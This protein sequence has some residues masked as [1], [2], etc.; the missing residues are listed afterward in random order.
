MAGVMRGDGA[1]SLQL[2]DV[3]SHRFLL[4][5]EETPARQG[6]EL[7][8]T[9]AP[10]RVILRSGV[11]GREIYHLLSAG[12]ARSLLAKSGEATAGQAAAGLPAVPALDASV[13]ADEAPDRCIVL[14][15][16]QPS[17]F[18]DVD[19]DVHDVQRGRGPLDLDPEIVPRVLA[20]E[21]EREVEAGRTVSLLVALTHT[22]LAEDLG[23]PLALPIGSQVDVYVRPRRGF[24]LEGPR[25][26]S[27]VVTEDAE[28]L[29]VQFR[30]RAASSLGEGRVEVLAFHRGRCLGRLSLS[31]VIT[32]E[33]VAPSRPARY[34]KELHPDGAAEPDLALIIHE[35][36]DPARPELLIRLWSAEPAIQVKEFGPIRLLNDPREHFRSFFL[37][38]EALGGNDD[39]ARA[40]A[41]ER[42]ER[43]GAELFQTLLPEDLRVLLWSLRRRIGSLRVESEEP[44][45]PWEL[46]RLVGHEAGQIVESGFFCEE[47]VMG[48]WLLGVR[49][50]PALRLRRI[51]LIVPA[52]AGLRRAKEERDKV[53]GLEQE[54]LRVEP[55]SCRYLP[56]LSAFASGTYDGFHFAGHATHRDGD[57]NRSRILLDEEEAL[58]PEDLSGKVAN[59]GR[60]WP[61]VFLNA[62]QTGRNSFSLTD[63]GGWAPKLLGAGAGAFLGALW[64]VS[65]KGAEVFARTFYHELLAEK[66]PI[67]EAVRQARR[68]V[69]TELPGNPAWLA[70]TLFAEPLARVTSHSAQTP[71]NA[72][73]A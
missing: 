66:K 42:L 16:D 28:T 17:G 6:K 30:L 26:A 72:G 63:L 73:D 50:K 13:D 60:T 2:R 9:L 12:E 36:G 70:Y 47:F 37:D 23:L 59:L 62:C 39:E 1:A 4:L 54:G 51:G 64:E 25:E 27:L 71:P 61:L 22:G 8:E 69:R 68:A 55:I 34:E 65:D 49:P 58:T 15:E 53:L 7:I 52:S 18:F 38:V 31:A 43:K 44:W 46:C 24:E 20:A 19:V 29:P 14:D 67:G 40:L 21:M 32:R 35:I 48:R 11:P 45:I 10:E 3:A 5:R 56:I 41:I 33:P 57:P